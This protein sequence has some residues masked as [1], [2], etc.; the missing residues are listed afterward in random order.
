MKRILKVNLVLAIVVAVSSLAAGSGHESKASVN[1]VTIKAPGIK[2]SGVIVPVDPAVDENGDPIAN[3]VVYNSFCNP[4]NPIVAPD[5]HLV[6]FSEWVHAN[7]SA[8]MQCLGDAGTRVNVQLTGLL[9]N[10]VYTAWVLAFD[11]SGNLL[12][13]GALGK[14]DGSQNSFQA[15][16]NGRGRISAVQPAGEL[17]CFPYNVSSCLL[18]TPG[19]A[20]VQIHIGYH[21]DGQTHGSCF[22][23]DC[24]FAVPIGFRFPL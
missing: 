19:V 23:G 22:G 18:D 16:A 14:S 3:P 4:I 7:G 9:P 12:G 6:T 21:L 15:D 8:S 5:G 11:S 1:G 13:L 24:D 10:G 17:S 20:E 2:D